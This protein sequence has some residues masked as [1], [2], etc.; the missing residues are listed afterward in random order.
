MNVPD[1]NPSGIINTP[2]PAVLQMQSVLELVLFV[3]QQDVKKN[4]KTEE[5]QS[6]TSKSIAR[7]SF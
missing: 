4:F 7:C 5:K 2:L 3:I 6:T 1:C